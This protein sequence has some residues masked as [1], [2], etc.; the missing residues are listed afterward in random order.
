MALLSLV[1]LTCCK[2]TPATPPSTPS[3]PGGIED[4]AKSSI[5]DSNNGHLSSQSTIDIDGACESTVCK[6]DG[7]DTSDG[8]C[9]SEIPSEQGKNAIQCNFVTVCDTMRLQYRPLNGRGAAFS[10]K[11]IQ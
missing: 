4:S 1:L 7:V 10:F 9:F 8:W 3:P 6:P 2:N 11:K 5:P